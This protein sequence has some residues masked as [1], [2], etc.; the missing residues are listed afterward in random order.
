MPKFTT[1]TAT[2]IDAEHGIIRE[3]DVSSIEDIQSLVG[4]YFDC[5]A[6]DDNETLYVNDEGRAF[7]FLKTPLMRASAILM[8]SSS[9][10]I[11]MYRN[12]S[13]IAAL[14]VLPDPLKGSRTSP[15]GGV[16]KRHRYR[17][18]SVGFTVG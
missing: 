16:T 1:K 10:S 9:F 11:P 13:S 18:S 7:Y 6:M 5:V 17:I 12:P 14:P 2:L 15:L 3:V 4:G 8:Y